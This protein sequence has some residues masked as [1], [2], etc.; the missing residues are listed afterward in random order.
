[1]YAVVLYFKRTLCR[2]NLA[3]M[4]RSARIT[5]AWTSQLSCTQ[6][7]LIN[8]VPLA[9]SIRAYID[10]DMRDS[11]GSTGHPSTCVVAFM[12]SYFY[13]QRPRRMVFISFQLNIETHYMKCAVAKRH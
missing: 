1:M 3:G 6:T 9:A 10:R 11:V 8:P 2:F 5:W 7:I 4:D 12:I 13:S